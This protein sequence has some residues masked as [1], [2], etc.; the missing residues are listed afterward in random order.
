MTNDST[1]FNILITA[2]QQNQVTLSPYLSGGLVN[3]QSQGIT[4]ADCTPLANA[5]HN[6][7]SVWSRHYDTVSSGGI[8]PPWSAHY[9]VRAEGTD[10]TYI[11]PVIGAGY[12]EYEGTLAQGFPL[13]PLQKDGCDY[14]CVI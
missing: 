5:L 1:A 8:A 6:N 9:D 3:L 12:Y 4:N 14:F 7:T 10:D 2:I 11:V 13:Q